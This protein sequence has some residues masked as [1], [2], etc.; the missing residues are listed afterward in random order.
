MK[1]I[2]NKLKNKTK[3]VGKEFRQKMI[4]YILAAFGLV[5]A[6][7]WNDTIKSLIEHLFPLEKNNILIKFIYALIITF[8]IVIISISLAKFSS[9]K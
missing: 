9:E 3:E 5:A 1:Q 2:K 6:L 7:A 4:S 8:V